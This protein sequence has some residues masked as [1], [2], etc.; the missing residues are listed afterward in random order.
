MLSAPCSRLAR[1][2]RVPYTYNL[3]LP[4]H[5][6]L[7]LEPPSWE[8][9]KAHSSQLTAR[10]QAQVQ[11]QRTFRR[12]F[13]LVPHNQSFSPTSVLFALF[14][15]N[16]NRPEPDPCFLDLSWFAQPLGVLHPSTIMDL[17]QACDG[18]CSR[19]IHTRM[20]NAWDSP[21]RR[22]YLSHK[23]IA[24]SPAHPFTL[25][26]PWSLHRARR[27]YHRRSD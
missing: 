10:Q 21:Y 2:S 3:Q 24:V 11:A 17:R 5:V 8:A 19:S 14:E 12:A 16:R 9:G 22:C 7:L 13:S 23:C 18:A 20:R 4:V 15:S 27:R 26:R 6:R 1:S 25:S